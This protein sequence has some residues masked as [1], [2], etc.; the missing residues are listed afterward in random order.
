[1]G[2]GELKTCTYG[3]NQNCVRITT[4]L[5]IEPL[6][7]ASVLGEMLDNGNR[8]FLAARWRDEKRHANRVAASI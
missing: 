6:H 3:E 7:A 5:L 1:M 2:T 4:N 8:A